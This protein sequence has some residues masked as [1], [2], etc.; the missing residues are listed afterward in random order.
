MA[1]AGH[2]TV[3]RAMGKEKEIPL[4]EDNTEGE[5]SN[6]VDL[7]LVRTGTG[8]GM[9]SDNWL[10]KMAPGTEFVVRDK[11][12]S[13]FMLARFTVVET[14]PKSVLLFIFNKDLSDVT[15]FG[16]VEPTRFINRFN[17]VEENAPKQEETPE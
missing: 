9:G 3:E 10:L 1:T 14:S 12:A 7:S 5:K 2:P 15:P 4:E 8:G 11:D 17:L 16:E 13:N 6:V